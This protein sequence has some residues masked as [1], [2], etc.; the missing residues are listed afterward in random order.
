MP[1]EEPTLLPFRGIKTGAYEAIKAGHVT[2]KETGQIQSATSR[3]GR[4]ARVKIQNA[5]A[6]RVTR[7]AKVFR[8]ANVRAELDLM[9][10]LHAGPVIY[11]L[12]LVF[13]FRKGAVAA[14]NVQSVSKRTVVIA[15]IQP[16]AVEEEGRQSG[17]IRGSQ[18]QSRN[19]ERSSGICTGIRIRRLRVITEPPKSHIGQPLGADRFVEARS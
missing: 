13:F 3:L 15:L 5:G 4:V 16:V 19:T 6:I 2:Q 14:A 1:V 7:H 8:I 18:V 10:A 11:D 17:G 9:V 12:E